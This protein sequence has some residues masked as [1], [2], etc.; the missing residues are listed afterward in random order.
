MANS[1]NSFITHA[2]RVNLAQITCG[3]VSTIPKISH[4]AFGDEGLDESGQPLDPTHR[5]EN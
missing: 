2:R 5:Y 1:K 4:I 3:A